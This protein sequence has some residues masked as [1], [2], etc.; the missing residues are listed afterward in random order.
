[1]VWSM[2]KEKSKKKKISREEYSDIRSNKKKGL[3]SEHEFKNMFIQAKRG[4]LWRNRNL[5]SYF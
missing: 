2:Q 1:M 4:G 5:K 3:I